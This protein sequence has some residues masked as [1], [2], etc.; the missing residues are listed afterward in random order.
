M[1]NQFDFQ[2]CQLLARHAAAEGCVLLENRNQ[3]LPLPNGCRVAVFGRIQLNYYTSGAGSGGLV[4]TDYTVDIVEGLQNSGKVLVDEA[5]LDVYRRW[6]EEHP[7]AYGTGWAQEPRC[8]LE[9]PLSEDTVRAVAERN[10]A[11]IVI[12]GRLAGE[13]FDHTPES[14]SYYLTDTELAMLRAVRTAFSRMIVLLNTGNIIDLG[15]SDEICPDALLL[16]WQGGQEGGN[17]VA[18]VLTGAVNPSGRL[19]DT[20]ASRLE[21][22]PSHSHFG[23]ALNNDYAEDIYLGYRWFETFAPEDVRYPFGYGLS[24]T[25]FDVQAGHCELIGDSPMVRVRVSNTGN[26][27]GREVVQFYV[28]QPHGAL[29]KPALTLVDF[30]KTAPL[31]P[32]QGE[33]VEFTVDWYRLASYDD[34]GKSGYPYCYVLEAGEY[35]LFAG[36]DSRTLISLGTLTVPETRVIRQC[37]QTLAPVKTFERRTADGWEFVPTRQ[38]DL[39]ARILAERPENATYTGD[40]GYKLADVLAGKIDMQ[41]F[42]AQLTDDDLA[43]MSCGEGMGSPK[44][45]AGTGGAFGGVTDRLLDF[46]IPVVCCTDGPSGIRMDSGAKAFSHPCGTLLACT[47]DKRLNED[48]FEQVGAEMVKLRIEVL[49]GPGMNLHRHPLNGRNFEYFSEDPVLTGEIGAAQ[50]RGLHRRGVTGCIKH[51]CANNQEYHRYTVSSNA[52]ERALRELYLK[53]YEIAVREGEADCIMTTYGALNDIWTAGNYDLNTTVLR[54]EWGYTGIVMTDWW[55]DINEEG[56]SPGKTNGGFMIRAQNDL[57]M[58]CSNPAASEVKS[59]ILAA[60]SE[61]VITRGQLVRSAAN[62]CRFVMGTAAMD[63]L[64]HPERYAREAEQ[65]SVDTGFFPG[66]VEFVRIGDGD[67]LDL[68]GVCTEKGKEKLLS[69]QTP[70]QG[71]YWYTLTA[72]SEASELAQMPITIFVGASPLATHVVHGTNGKLVA[73]TGH[74]DLTGTSSFIRLRFGQS[75]IRLHSIAFFDEKPE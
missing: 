33:T 37:R 38:Y 3:C 13:D 43:C 25:T 58:V 59:N 18:D 49:L 67:S 63:R 50:I 68:S 12:L 52:S 1:E 31:P 10:D 71:R 5:L 36:H 8:Q 9:M 60:L 55:A 66:D 27:A 23:D 47:F 22:H 46:G 73:L 6:V 42:L 65:A 61:G 17:G 24:Y 26:C 7:F 34:S 51:F 16:V 44:V 4:N 53:G 19:C 35:A 29:G 21:N 74:I 41:T 11:A 45:T 62:I 69:I 54:G 70:R 20:I 64:L 14:G 32:G 30:D 28:R 39:P 75:G 57:Y 72:S 48:L 56:Q 15:W 2:K 40:Q